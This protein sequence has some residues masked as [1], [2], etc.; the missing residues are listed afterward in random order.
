MRVLPWMGELMWA[1]VHIFGF[2]F[3]YFG[4]VKS[5][6]QEIKCKEEE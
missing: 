1:G 3:R 6:T 2:A 4:S 5:K